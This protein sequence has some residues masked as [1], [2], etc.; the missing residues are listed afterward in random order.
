MAPFQFRR[1]NPFY[2][3]HVQAAVS[4]AAAAEAVEAEESSPGLESSPGG[5][6]EAKP[7]EDSST[8]AAQLATQLK[9]LH[10]P[11]FNTNTDGSGICLQIYKR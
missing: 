11:W 9:F 2:F 3:V 8:K 1:S 5:G 6:Q 4:A 7:I 10:N